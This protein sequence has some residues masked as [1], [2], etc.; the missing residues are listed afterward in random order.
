MRLVI[1]VGIVLFVFG[2]AWVLYLDTQDKKFIENLS[3]PPVIPKTGLDI[4]PD[5]DPIEQATSQKTHATGIPGDLMPDPPLV[6]LHRPVHSHSSDNDSNNFTDPRYLTE[7]A[8]LV[9][10]KTDEKQH[11]DLS[12]VI[13]GDSFNYDREKIRQGLIHEFGDIPEVDIILQ[14]MPAEIKDGRVLMTQIITG[15]A[16][17]LEYHKAIA[18]LWPTPENVRALERLKELME[19]RG[20]TLPSWVD[21]DTVIYTYESTETPD[22]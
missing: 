8:R 20:G 19:W 16:N 22:R 10:E 18:T 4:D 5:S 2:C 17:V 3:Q 9:E 6:H 1:Y 13:L 15:D 11:A 12:Q 21:P 7:G 14:N